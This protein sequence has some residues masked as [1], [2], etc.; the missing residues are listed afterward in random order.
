MDICIV[1]LGLMGGSAAK[2]LAGFTKGLIHAV[3]IDAGV[4]DKALGEGVI[5]EGHTDAAKALGRCG[6]VLLCLYPWDCVKFIKENAGHFRR[7]AVITDMSGI[8]E[9]VHDKIAGFL[10]EGV[11]FVGAHPMAGREV[12]GYGASTAELFKGC[13]YIITP[14]AK[15]K[16]ES[17]RLVRSVAKHLGSGNIVETTPAEHDS[18]IA[19]TSQLMH[20]V[21]VSLSLCD[22]L[23]AAAPFSAGSLRDCTRV[24]NINSGLWAGLF[25]ENG[26]NLAR[27]I[28]ELVEN[29]RELSLAVKNGD[30]EKVSALMDSAAKRKQLFLKE[31]G[32]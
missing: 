4:L 27:E 31:K 14:S 15:N 25:L 10:P 3:D 16:E 9:Y 23:S 29:L 18:M 12:G 21:A 17:I 13:N 19:Y 26:Q 7:G 1:G 24:A 28:D 8:K 11:D 22:K 5:D 30:L 6:L 32:L 20:A 2:A